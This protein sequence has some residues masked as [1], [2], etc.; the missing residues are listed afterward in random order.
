MENKK[1]QWSSSIGFILASAGSAAGLGNIWKFPARAYEG[2]G[3]IYLIVYILIVIFLGAPLMIMETSLGRYTGKNAVAAYKSINKKWAVAGYFGVVTGFLVSCYYIQLGGWVMRYFVAYLFESAKLFSAPDT[4]FYNMLG[5]NGFPFLSAV[6]YPVLFLGVCIFVILKGV[7]GGIEKFSFYVMPLFMVLLIVLLVRSVTL[8][9]A[10]EGVE[11]MLSF[12]IT[13]FSFSALLSALGQ[14]FY[15]LSVGLGVMITYGAYLK[16]DCNI[17]KDTAFICLFDTAVAI[18]AA[19]IIIPAVFAANTPAGS[20]GS[21]V[22]IS[23]AGVFESMPFGSLFGALFYLLLFFAAV[24]S[25]IS[26]FETVLVFAENELKFERK[27]TT[28]AISAIMLIV[29]ALYT[30]SQIYLPVKALWFDVSDGLRL[31]SFGDF[32][33]LFTDR[34]T[35]P[36]GAFLSCVFAG[37]VWKKENALKEIESG[38]K[39]GFR[40]KNYWLFTIRYIAP[41]CVFVIFVCGMLF[42]VSVS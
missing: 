33:E 28:A 17:P 19:F 35:I 39:N 24:T 5:A 15:S 4:F 32:I 23:L 16:K 40:F 14:A 9:G 29:G 31:V 27:K 10:L 38:A 7:S 2:G 41:I 26:I 8:P 30:L 1:Q 42:G 13:K 37:F 21:F 18:A 25:E 3:G 22:F 36:I 11:Y 34:F 12:D 6:F 20:G